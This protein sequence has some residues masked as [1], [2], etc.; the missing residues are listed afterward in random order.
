MPEL[1][2]GLSFHLLLLAVAA[3]LAGALSLF[4]YRTTVP[5]IPRRLRI[6]L[7]ILRSLALFLLFLVIGEPL[8]SFIT[9]TSE[10]P[11]VMVLIDNS[12]SMGIRDGGGNRKEIVR[13][14]LA[15][16]TAVGLGSSAFARSARHDVRY[17]LFDS[18]VRTL[19]AFATDS[20]TFSGDGTD[21]AKALQ[22]AKETATTSASSVEP[23]H[24]IQS[25][26]LIS[27]GNSTTGSNPL[28][29]AMELG[30]PVFTIG[31]GDTSEQKDILIRKAIT[32]A[33]TYVGDRVPVQVTLKSTGYGGERVEV[34]LSDEKQVVD[35]KIV[36]LER[37]TR[38]YSLTFGYVPE[39]EG[40]QKLTVSVSPLPG[41]LTTQNNRFSL[42]TRVLKSKMKVLMIA[43]S[44]SP[45]VAFIRRTLGNDP[46][47]EVTAR[48]E[49]STSSVES[50]KDGQF[51]E[52]ALTQQILDET[53]CLVLVGFPTSSSPLQTVTAVLQAVSAGKGV[54]L[55]LSRTID[56]A[57]LRMLD[58][59]LP[60]TVVGGSMP[61]RPMPARQS[62]SG[63]AGGEEYQ[64]FLAV[65]ESHLTHPILKLTEA[66]NPVETWS[67]LPPLFKSQAQFIAKPESE[68]LAQTRI[69]TTTL[70][71]PLLV[72]RTMNKRK[73]VAFLGYGVWRWKTLSD[74]RST[75]VLDQFLSNTVRWLT[76]REDEKQIRVRTSKEQFTTQEVVDFT[77]QVYDENYRP[78]ENA[79]VVAA[80]RRD[81][82]T[83][84]L[85]L[86]P[87]GNG[88]YEGSLEG[89]EE[90]DY[91][92]SAQVTVDGNN[93]GDDRGSFS[94]GG[95]NVEFLETRMNKPQLE[96][97]AA[98]TGG[99]YYDPSTLATLADD[100]ASL[101]NFQPRERV[102]SDEI[103][104]WSSHW[105]LAVIVI[106]FALEWFLRKRNGML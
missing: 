23:S 5:P 3:L 6:T 40:M 74:E 59:A 62:G 7:T 53:E 66:Q 60:V 71:D 95:V 50:R 80:I 42:F 96:Q 92:Y 56:L 65:R 43:G 69:Q 104:V 58:Q 101:H 94:V 18:R 19:T 48:I 16:Q 44:P 89:L 52:G 84:E 70:T 78:I 93:I 26:V 51:Y 10:N 64:A 8:L 35:Q 68:I 106:L 75:T 88:Q 100:I 73:S 21:I 72:T 29:E 86:D 37:G 28:Y 54:L 12:Q 98:R 15:R 41:E 45:D 1:H 47:I 27:D 2:L 22:H 36:T 82:R 77:A 24:N 30:I 32:N 81:G 17:A 91:K 99:K 49:T 25:V 76:T 34:T 4:V 83:H 46:N 97:I 79:H 57:R 105:T 13:R 87:L 38:E 9:R 39:T 33:I 85:R 20:I 55:F 102:F 63:G 31:I 90:G 61:A 14:V 67:R 11:T 103:Q